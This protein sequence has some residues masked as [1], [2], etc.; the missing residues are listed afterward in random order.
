M[1]LFMHV[2]NEDT[3]ITQWNNIRLIITHPK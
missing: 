2:L 1:T 3:D